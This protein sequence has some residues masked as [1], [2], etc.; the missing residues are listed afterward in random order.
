MKKD[1]SARGKFTKEYHE[2]MLRVRKGINKFKSE[3]HELMSC[4]IKIRNRR[5]NKRT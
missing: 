5:E 2:Y 3:Y 1:V 4:M